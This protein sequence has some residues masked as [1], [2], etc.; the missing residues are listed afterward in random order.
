MN[1]TFDV[2][3]DPKNNLIYYE[4]SELFFLEV[5]TSKKTLIKPEIGIEGYYATDEN[6]KK[7]PMHHLLRFTIK[8]KPFCLM[9]NKCHF[10]VIVNAVYNLFERAN[11]IRDITPFVIAEQKMLFAKN[12]NIEVNESLLDGWFKSDGYLDI[13]FSCQVAS[14]MPHNIEYIKELRVTIPLFKDNSMAIVQESIE[15]L[16]H[17]KAFETNKRFYNNYSE[18]PQQKIVN[19]GMKATKQLTKKQSQLMDYIIEE[20]KSGTQITDAVEFSCGKAGYKDFRQSWNI[21][22]DIRAGKLT[23]KEFTEIDPNDQ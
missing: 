7:L 22:K 19:V 4:G 15:S 5:K 18:N 1:L 10:E 20:L 23:C 6:G 2:T 3:T 9:V 16:L 11:A 12:Y 21:I 13:N 14:F 8:E 17:K